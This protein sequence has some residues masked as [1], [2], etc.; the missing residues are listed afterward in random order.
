MTFEEYQSRTLAPGWLQDPDGLGWNGALGAQK[1][2]LTAAAKEAV[3][4]R[5]PELAPEDALQ[6]LA[7]ERGIDRGQTETLEG[8]RG[9]VLGAWDVWRWAGTPFSLLA[10]FW[11]A[12]YTPA[13]GRIILQTQLGKQHELRADYD[14]FVHDPQ[15]AVVTTDIGVVHLGGVPELWNQFALVFVPPTP[16][17]WLPT[18]PADGSAEVTAIRRLIV[19]WKPAH[20]QC[21]SLKVSTQELW[22]F[23]T[24]VWEPTTEVWDEAGVET[25]WTP[26]VG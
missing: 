8:F 22:D 18:P 6:L 21:V 7:I 4:A 19:R 17:G 11:W 2:I 12:G 23:P 9:R 13:S 26:P 24:E 1:D 15:D 20:A 16:P 3:K 5:F 25:V 10:A 14:P